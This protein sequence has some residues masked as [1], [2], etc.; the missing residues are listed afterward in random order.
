MLDAARHAPAVTGPDLA[1]VGPDP[2]PDPASHKVAGL[3]VRVD[4]RREDV[5]CRQP[6]LGHHGPLAVDEHPETDSGCGLDQAVIAAGGERNDARPIL[7]AEGADRSVATVVP[8]ALVVAVV[9]AALVV[10]VVAVVTRIARG[11]RSA[12]ILVARLRPVVGIA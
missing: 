8:A 12:V 1:D 3:L 5:S 4:V 7:H 9:A 6:E 2:K 11:R 10:A